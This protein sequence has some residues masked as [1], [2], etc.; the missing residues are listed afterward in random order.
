[1]KRNTEKSISG[2]VVATGISSVIAQLLIIREYLTQFQGN[3]YVIALIFFAWLLLGGLGSYTAGLITDRFL[4]PDA[5][6]LVLFSF[7]IAVLPVAELMT[8]RLARDFIFTP[9]TS[10]GFYATFLFIFITLGP[11]GFLIGLVLPYSLSVL[12]FQNPGYPGTKVYILDNIGDFTGGALFSFV[13]ITLASPLQAIMVSGILLA[14]AALFIEVQA[15]RLTLKTIGM[16]L[17]TG[18]ILTAGLFWEIPSLLPQT[19][20]MAWYRESRYGRITVIKNREQMTIFSDGVPLTG[21]FDVASAEASVHYPMS[22]TE[23]PQ[24]VLIISAGGG[25]LN[26]LEKYQLSS[27]DYVELNPE[28]AGA[29]FRFGLLKKIDGLNVINKDGRTYLSETDRQYDAVIINISDPE[30]FQTNRFYTGEFYRRVKKHL[31]PGGVMS[32]SIKGYANY[33]SETKIK[34]ISSLYRT[35][36]KQFENVLVLP[37][38]RIFFICSDGRLFKDIPERLL[39]KGIT[40]DY[41]S[42]YFYGNVTDERVAEIKKQLDSSIPENSDTNPYLMRLM[43]SQWF[44][45]FSTTPQWLYLGLAILLALY[46]FKITK[47][48]YLLFSTG[49]MTMG[50]EILVIFAFQIFFGYLYFQISLI[51]TVFLAG[52]LPGALLG[53]RLGKNAVKAILI[54]DGLLILMCLLFAMIILPENADP[55]GW[56]ILLFGFCVSVL[57]GCQFPLALKSGG[58]DDR[59]TSFAFTADLSGAACGA[60]LTSVLLIPYL[61]L[62][63][64]L[65]ALIGLKFSSI[66]VTLIGVR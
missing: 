61:G 35:V 10:T 13:L 8:I 55:Q 12:R 25:M 49:F 14:L 16:V 56:S 66:V 9:G 47:E 28:I 42:G 19:G 30:T 5:G 34:I 58:E 45:K 44:A 65:V 64:T 6:L 37:G 46:F 52:L 29:Q 27:V 57:C 20:Q 60:L 36:R 1:L 54:T 50:S 51:V 3:E 15:A 33:I 11:Y 48:E 31:K 32:F 41:V 59:K 17:A 39:Q 2:L 63:G 7:L 43:F 23:N 62:A 24:S 22:Q 18:S 38:G 21:K 40:T 53:Q 26:E 4:K